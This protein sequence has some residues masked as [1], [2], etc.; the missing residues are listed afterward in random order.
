MLLVQDDL[1]GMRSLRLEQPMYICL[2][3][4]GIFQCFHFTKT[5]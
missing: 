4:K 1:I 5:K 2:I 3:L